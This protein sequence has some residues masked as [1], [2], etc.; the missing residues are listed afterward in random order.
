MVSRSSVVLLTIGTP[1]DE[2]MNPAMTIFERA[3]GE[4]APAH[5]ARVAC[6]PRSTVYPGTTEYV[7]SAL[8]EHGVEV[9]VAFCPERIAEGH[10]LEEL[11]TLPQI[12]GAD[13]D[14]AGD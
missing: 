4:L 6:D 10:A 8:G 5:H 12:V 2:F 1:V 11:Q 13:N 7:R 14:T 9:E 3:L